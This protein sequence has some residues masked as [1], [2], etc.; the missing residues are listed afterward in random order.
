VEIDTSLEAGAGLEHGTQIF[1]GRPRVG[2]ALKHN[3]SP[4]SQVGRYHFPGLKHIRNVRLPVLIQGS[5]HTNDDRLHFTNPGEIFTGFK[6]PILAL[7]P[8]RLG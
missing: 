6:T 2:R 8:H 5:R 7:L 4:L 1:I 3:Q